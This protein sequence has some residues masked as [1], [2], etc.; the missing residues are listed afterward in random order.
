MINVYNLFSGSKEKHDEAQ[1]IIEHTPLNSEHTPLNSENTPLNSEHTPL[2][3]EHTPFSSEQTPLSSE[4]TPLST[5]GKNE[6]DEKEKTPKVKDHQ[7]DLSNEKFEEFQGKEIETKDEK[8]L[9]WETESTIPFRGQ[10]NPFK[11]Q[12]PS[13]CNPGKGEYDHT[14][15]QILK[16]ECDQEQDQILIGDCDQQQN[17]AL[18]RNFES[19]NLT[20]ENFDV[21][22]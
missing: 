13:S 12:E 3:T 22:R 8:E 14:Q 7:L 17:Q 11:T 19:L 20:L 10:N 1:P 9:F 15:D 18:E 21:P 5:E 2:N 16:G 4:H 6:K